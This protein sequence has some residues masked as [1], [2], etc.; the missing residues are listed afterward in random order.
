M[1][2][3]LALLSLLVSFAAFA[4]PP[5]DLTVTFNA[6]TTGGAP[7]GYRLYIN[8]CQPTGPQAAP[9]ADVTSGQ[10]FTGALTADGV[11][12]VC[13]RP[14]NATGE[15][16]DPGPVAIVDV[17]D[18]PLPGP[19]TNLQIQIDCPNGGCTVNVSTQ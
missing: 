11:Y 2:K 6:P 8:D 17:S 7:D 16:A 15:L 4:A 14:Y 19:I 10:T 9:F 5:Y 1:K 3:V 13:V 18:L 12:Q